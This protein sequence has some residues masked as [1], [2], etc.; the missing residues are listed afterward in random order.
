MS[1]KTAMEILEN[2]CDEIITQSVSP[3]LVEI[4]KAHDGYLRFNLCGKRVLGAHPYRNGYIL[5]PH[6]PDDGAKFT[7]SGGSFKKPDGMYS[8]YALDGD[9]VTARCFYFAPSKKSEI[10]SNAIKCQGWGGIKNSGY[11]PRSQRIFIN[12]CDF[13]V[14]TGKSPDNYSVLDGYWEWEI[15]GRVA[16][17][18]YHQKKKREHLP[19]GIQP[20]KS[21][22]F[23][24]PTDFFVSVGKPLNQTLPTRVDYVKK[25]IIFEAPIETCELCGR[26][27][28]H[29]EI[30]RVQACQTCMFTLEEVREMSGGY[31]EDTAETLTIALNKVSENLAAC[32]ETVKSLIAFADSL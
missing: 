13:W 12:P 6:T 21:S 16:I 25:Q 29:N 4:K 30:R 5:T 28:R 22:Y 23:Y 1:T 15:N 20:V 17:L 18:K 11:V 32:S 24:L 2:R 19:L 8:V 9:A 14:L 7:V 26:P 27:L 10:A 3:R 31:R